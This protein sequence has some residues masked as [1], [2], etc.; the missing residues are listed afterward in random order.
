MGGELLLGLEQGEIYFLTESSE[1]ADV[2]LQEYGTTVS[3]EDTGLGIEVTAIDAG[4][5]RAS[6]LRQADAALGTVV[7]NRLL[8]APGA[9]PKRH[10][11]QCG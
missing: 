3:E 11:G 5:S 2:R 4:T 8:T 10:I 9:P 7:E 6:A 1:K